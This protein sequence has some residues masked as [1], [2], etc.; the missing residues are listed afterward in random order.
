[1]EICAPPQGIRGQS[2]PPEAENLL[3]FGCPAE[4]AIL[5]HAL[6]FANSLNPRYCDT[7]LKKLKVSS[8]M[9]WTILATEKQFKIV[10]L[11]MCEVSTK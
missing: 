3:A 5:P 10:L 6:Y 4:A 2:H 8:K 7:S 9:A 11:V 1:M